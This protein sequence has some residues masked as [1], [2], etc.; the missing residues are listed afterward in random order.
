MTTKQK[1]INYLND[2]MIEPDLYE[3][4][5]VNICEILGIKFIDEENGWQ[6]KEGKS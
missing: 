5:I 6:D 3:D 1:I 4:H 2:N